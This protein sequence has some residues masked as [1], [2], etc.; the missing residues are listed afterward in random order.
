LK[1]GKEITESFYFEDDFCSGLPSIIGNTLP[2]ASIIAIY[3]YYYLQAD[4]KSFTLFENSAHMPHY[5]E[6]GKFRRL[7]DDI[8]I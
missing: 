3:F 4:T 1:N 8:F 6:P 5:E 2:H 7:I